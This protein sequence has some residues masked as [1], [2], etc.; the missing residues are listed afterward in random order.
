MTSICAVIVLFNPDREFSKSLQIFSAQVEKVFIIDNSEFGNPEQYG[1]AD[2][3]SV[4]TELVRMGENAGI[5]RALNE[6]MKRAIDDGY[7]FCLLMD[8]DSVLAPNAVNLLARILNE[9]PAVFIAAPVVRDING[10]TG[11]GVA[12]PCTERLTCITSGSLVNLKHV[13]RVGYHRED[14]FIDLVDHEYCLRARSMGLRVVVVN[15]AIL[16]HRLGKMEKRSFLGMD[17]YPTHH[18]PERRYYK[19]RNSIFLWKKYIIRYPRY[20]LPAM[21]RLLK[22]YLEIL[23]FEQDRHKKFRMILKGFAHGI[24]GRYGKL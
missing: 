5:A 14:L 4:N 13:H 15:D 2:A 20:V 9:D 16:N 24:T 18:S 1:Y 17:F 10:L 21:L 6:G 3:A 23:L 11:A 12:G 19:A 8:Q 22:G 7:D